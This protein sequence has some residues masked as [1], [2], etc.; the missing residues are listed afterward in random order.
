[1]SG[2]EG[3]V[4]AGGEGRGVRREIQDFDL[5]VFGETS[6]NEDSRVPAGRE[7]RGFRLGERGKE[8]DLGIFGQ[9]SEEEAHSSDSDVIPECD[10][11]GAESEAS[12][13]DA[14]VDVLYLIA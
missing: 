4:P 8:F 10:S 1:M 2:S 5:G 7:G 12:S 9:V 3:R 14:V 13:T 11:E 6:D